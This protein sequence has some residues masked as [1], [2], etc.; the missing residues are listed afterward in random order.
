MLEHFRRSV[1]KLFENFSTAGS[2]MTERRDGVFSP[3][4][5]AGWTDDQMNLRVVL[6]GVTRDDLTV[7]VQ[8]RQLIIE[9]ERKAPENFGK[10]GFTYSSMPYGRFQ[11]IV[12]LPDGLS[13][14]Q[15]TCNLHDGVLD[16][17]IPVAELMKPRLIPISSGSERKA[18]AAA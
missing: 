17:G 14:E 15:V 6:P 18:V 9:G 7:R 4:V 12:S 1:D 16:I 13:M 2:L 8:G 5:E 11:S 10:E 3:A